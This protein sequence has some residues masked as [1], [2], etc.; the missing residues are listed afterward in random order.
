MPEFMWTNTSHDGSREKQK[1]KIKE[2]IEPAA[3]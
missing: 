2:E 3:C 1:Q